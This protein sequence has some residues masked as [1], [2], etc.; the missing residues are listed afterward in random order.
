[1]RYD[2]H[3]EENL[4]ARTDTAGQKTIR[5]YSKEQGREDSVSD[6]VAKLLPSQA[7]RQER[8]YTHIVGV[9]VYRG[10]GRLQLPG[11]ARVTRRE[12]TRRTAI[13][14]YIVEQGTPETEMSTTA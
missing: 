7:A 10:G 9:E 1:M 13:H 5:P 12:A 8:F 14:P 11:S 6:I 4:A 2:G 3:S